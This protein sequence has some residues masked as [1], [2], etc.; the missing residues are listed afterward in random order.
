MAG[1][2]GWM[3]GW[4]VD[5]RQ[6]SEAANDHEKAKAQPNVEAVVAN[7][8]LQVAAGAEAVVRG[9]IALD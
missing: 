7:E 1:C 6:W 9:E 8:V 2:S 5:S 4:V 3:G